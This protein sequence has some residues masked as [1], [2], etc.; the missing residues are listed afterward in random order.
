MRNWYSYRERVFRKKLVED[1]PARE[2]IPMASGQVITREHMDRGVDEDE[3]RVMMFT[4]ALTSE[5]AI[6]C[7][8][9]AFQYQ[10]ATITSADHNRMHENNLQID[11]VRH[12][13]GECMYSSGASYKGDWRY[14]KRDGNGSFT[15]TC[16]DS[17]S[18]Q[19]MRGK[20][21]GI[22]KYTSSRTTAKLADDYDGEW[23]ED[24]PDGVGLYRYNES[25]DQYEGAFESGLRTGKGKYTFANGNVYEGAYQFGERS[26]PGKFSYASGEAEA[27]NYADGRDEGDGVRWSA[28]RSSAIHLR[29]GRDVGPVSLEKAA[30]IA[31][32]LGLPVPPPA[33]SGLSAPVPAA[34]P[35]ETTAAALGMPALGAPALGAPVLVAPT[36]EGMAGFGSPAA[37]AAPET[38]PAPAFGGFSF[39]VA[40]P[41]R[42]APGASLF[43]GLFSP[44]SD[45]TSGAAPPSCGV[46]FGGAPSG[47][48]GLPPH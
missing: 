48:C 35:T 30:T 39:P 17:Y 26:G 37:P 10:G 47:L 2:K 46:L 21:H 44:R 31:A 42:G 40:D 33:S 7:G 22:G 29:D 38:T 8:V 9:G 4:S 16:G 27:G 13:Y 45:A 43:T 5:R 18:G 19:W 24:R 28:D 1:H 34:A 15:Y 36:T 32:S 11:Q 6:K 14:D 25:G 23:K 41:S 12:G 20:Y 3:Q